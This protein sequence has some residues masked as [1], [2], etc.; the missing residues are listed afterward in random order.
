MNTYFMLLRRA[1]SLGNKT[2][3]RMDEFAWAGIFARAGVQLL[4]VYTVTGAFDVMLICQAESNAPIRKLVRE[5][6]GWTTTSML[7]VTHVGTFQ[8]SDAL[9][10]ATWLPRSRCPKR[11]ASMTVLPAAPA[12]ADLLASKKPSR[13]PWKPHQT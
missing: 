5:L 11:P 1:Q 6:D 8:S 10:A 2:A 4:D 9:T 7:A 3:I 13:N 12:L